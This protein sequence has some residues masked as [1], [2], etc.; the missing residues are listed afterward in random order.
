MNDTLAERAPATPEDTA[1]EPH[2]G[3]RQA[4]V[5]LIEHLTKTSRFWRTWAVRAWA[6]LLWLAPALLVS[7]LLNLLGSDSPQ[8][9]ACKGS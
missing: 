5:A 9:A 7:V 6:V 3:A 8:L 4:Q 2:D 1:A